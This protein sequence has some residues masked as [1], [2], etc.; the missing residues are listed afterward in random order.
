[1]DAEADANGD[2]DG[3]GDEEADPAQ[4]PGAAS[5][6]SGSVRMLKPEEG[7]GCSERGLA[8]SLPRPNFSLD[9][10]RRVQYGR[11]REILLF[12]DGCHL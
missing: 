5:T 7:S 12:Y 1:V 3:K 4:L 6:F 9:I 11:D 8:W 2:D 10:L